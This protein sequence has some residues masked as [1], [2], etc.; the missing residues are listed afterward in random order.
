MSFIKPYY[1]N[2]QLKSIDTI[3]TTIETNL[4]DSKVND[5]E[6]EKTSR[7]VIGSNA[8]ALIFNGQGKTVYEKNALGELCLLDEKI[9]ISN[10]EINISKESLKVLEI[11]NESE[12][13]VESSSNSS[14]Y[15]VLIY[16]KKIKS[17]LS[18]YYLIINVP[19]EPIESYIDFIMNQYIY[20]G[21]IVTTIAI[22]IAFYLSNQIS[23][24]I[25][26]MK[27]EA[28]K[29]AQGNYNVEFKT[30]SFSEINDLANT[31]D[32]ATKK[33]SKVDEL[34]KDLVAN[35]SHDIKTPLTVIQSYAEMIKDISG[36]DPDKRNEHLDVIIK[37]SEYL[38]KLVSDMQIYSKMQAGYI[39][40]KKTNFD[41]KDSIEKVVSLLSHVAEEHEVKIIQHLKSVTVYGDEVKMSR[42][43]Y[44]FLSNAIKHSKVGSQVEIEMID[45]DIS[46]R[47]EIKDY[48]DGISEE[49][50]PYI[51]DRYYKIDK[52][53]NRKLES[54]GLGLAIAKAILEGHKA[55][56]GVISKEN[57]GSTFY[58]EMSKD[59]EDE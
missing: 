31:L 49:N 28:S 45:S 10:Q 11:L 48:G 25:V 32:N 58:F 15:E 53:F 41:M 29:L 47:V 50:I 27:N 2:S 44:N 17:N 5:N 33:L 3:V 18:D 42:V 1:R 13:N 51:W 20:I 21:L 52:G 54:T 14:G 59:Y 43:I 30:D 35:V 7:A 37:E 6:V 46:L 55:K 4:L 9:Q 34:R 19:L 39:E 36:D 40:L 38:N 8:C 26:K 56:Y 57:V 12:I 23:S 24:P 22:F 16:G